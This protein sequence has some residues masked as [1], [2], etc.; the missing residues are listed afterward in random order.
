MSFA[1]MFKVLGQVALLNLQPNG[2]T[3]KY[4]STGLSRINRG[5]FLED[6][7]TLLKLLEERQIQ[8]IIFK[9][10]PLMEAARANELLESGQVIG[11]VV[12]MDPELL[13]EK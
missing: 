11:N 3:A 4:Y 8:P 12:L 1:G 10:F 9:R 5:M 6:W 2:K 13:E 7:D